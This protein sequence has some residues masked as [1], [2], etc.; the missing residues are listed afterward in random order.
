MLKPPLQVRLPKIQF[1]GCESRVDAVLAIHEKGK[2][3]LKRIILTKDI[4]HTID[5]TEFVEGIVID[6]VALEKDFPLKIQNPNIALIDAPMEIGKTT[7]KAKLQIN[8]AADFE[9][10]IIQENAALLEMA[11]YII[12]AGANAVFCSKGMDDKIAAYL[13]NR[14]IYA[15]VGSRVRI[16][17]TL[18]TPQTEDS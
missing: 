14:G 12:R 6:K 2:A 13:Q 7:N 17:N 5:E 10:F 9:N 15:L 8:T 1:I 16:C 11:D 18:L 4:G 3:D